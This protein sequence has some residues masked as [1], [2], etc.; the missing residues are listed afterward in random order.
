MKSKFPL[1]ERLGLHVD[2]IVVS[3]YK[4]DERTISSTVKAEDLETLL[5]ESSKVYYSKIGNDIC[6]ITR[7]K[8]DL[9]SFVAI[10]IGE[11]PVP[12]PCVKCE[13]AAFIEVTHCVNCNR[14]LRRK[15]E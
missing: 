5:Q 3:N 6:S 15:Y 13:P 12:K 2:S 1:T 7:E 10:L 9:S 4:G 8:T 11:T 14:E